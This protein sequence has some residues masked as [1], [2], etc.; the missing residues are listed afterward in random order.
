MEKPGKWY[1]VYTKPR[2]EKK[3]DAMFGERGIMSYCPLNKVRR[4]WSDRFKVV[5]EPLFKSYV[6]VRITDKEMSAVR[7]VSGVIN[8]VYWNNKP[9]TI[10]DEEVD[11]IKR[12]LN[13]Y[14][15]VQVVPME[16]KPQSKVLITKGIMM[17]KEAEV[18]QVRSKMVEVIIEC[19][20]Y[21]L[22]AQINKSNITPIS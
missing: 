21:K 22:T 16:I 20:G 19:L 9:A 14:Q 11:Q 3:I 8:F 10:K 12:F 17:N 5:E 6:F 2:W 18:V 1:A 7:Q 13:E 4:K 15:E